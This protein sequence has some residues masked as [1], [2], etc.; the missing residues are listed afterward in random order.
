MPKK[1]NQKEE[2]RLKNEAYADRFKPIPGDDEEDEKEKKGKKTKHDALYANWC[3][4]ESHVPSC[5]CTYPPVEKE[6]GQY[7][8]ERV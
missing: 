4:I 5:N 1:I 6:R 8:R 7:R 3:R 2:K